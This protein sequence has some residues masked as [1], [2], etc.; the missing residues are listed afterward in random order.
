MDNTR[1]IIRKLAYSTGDCLV[2]VAETLAIRKA[3]KIAICL[4]MSKVIIESD[5]QI[6]INSSLGR[7][8]VPKQI[9]NL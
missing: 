5:S 4:E 2:L 6:A 3:F 9:K 8:Q 7:C 1:R